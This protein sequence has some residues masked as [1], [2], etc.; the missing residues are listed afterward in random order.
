MMKFKVVCDGTRAPLIYTVKKK[1]FK[2]VQV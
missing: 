2:I 1:D